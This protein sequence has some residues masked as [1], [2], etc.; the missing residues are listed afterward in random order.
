MFLF[1]RQIKAPII[2]TTLGGTLTEK[3]LHFM[4]VIYQPT[5]SIAP[6]HCTKLIVKGINLIAHA[7]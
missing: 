7:Q 3:S 4:R 5:K 1:Y 2:V 6:N